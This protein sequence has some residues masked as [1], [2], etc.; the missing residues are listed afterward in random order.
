MSVLIDSSATIRSHTWKGMSIQYDTG[1]S[2]LDSKDVTINNSLKV[3]D[4]QNII[5]KN[6]KYS[7]F[8][9]DFFNE[10]RNLSYLAHGIYSIT[11][12]EAKIGFKFLENFFKYR[13]GKNS[14]NMNIS[15]IFFEKEFQLMDF[16]KDDKYYLET[17]FSEHT[18]N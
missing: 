1:N 9:K 10:N 16:I 7:V 6:S 12:K 3:L 15:K 2:N 13:L 4:H 8:I 18:L 5:Q 14:Y 17:F 11:E